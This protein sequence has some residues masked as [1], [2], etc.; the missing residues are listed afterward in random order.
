MIDIQVVNNNSGE[1]K[2]KPKLFSRT[3]Q[4]RKDRFNK[5]VFVNMF[6]IC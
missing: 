1:Q 2:K 5:V 6:V 3:P 4:K